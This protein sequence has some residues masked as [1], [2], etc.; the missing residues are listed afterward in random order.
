MWEKET[1]GVN[2][3]SDRDVTV[4]VVMGG[5]SRRFRFQPVF[6]I[7]KEWW[8]GIPGYPNNI[9]ILFPSS[10]FFHPPFKSFPVVDR[11]RKNLRGPLN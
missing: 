8:F 1:G 7:F 11:G 3:G 10:R 2:R 9:L 5:V 6:P 4:V